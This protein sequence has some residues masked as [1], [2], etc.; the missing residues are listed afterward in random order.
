MCAWVWSAREREG[1][2][3]E[4][5]THV[6]VILCKVCGVTDVYSSKDTLNILPQFNVFCIYKA[7]PGYHQ[8]Q[9]PTTRHRMFVD[10][11]TYAHLDEAV[12]EFAKEIPPKSLRLME[13]IGNGEFWNV[14][15]GVWKTED[16]EELLITVKTLKVSLLCHYFCF[17]SVFSSQQHNIHVHSTLTI[18]LKYKR[19]SRKSWHSTHQ[20]RRC[21]YI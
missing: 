11:K 6:H 10:P 17:A 2:G 15:H 16:K 8:L 3:E 13:E 1:E 7:H 14:Y 20:T 5:S 19:Q 9:F 4:A 12:H 18:H 21:I